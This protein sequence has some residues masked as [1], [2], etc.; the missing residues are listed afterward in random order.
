M[1]STA[2]PMIPATFFPNTVL[3]S[4]KALSCSLDLKGSHSAN[5]SNDGHCLPVT[6]QAR[7]CAGSRRASTVCSRLG[8]R[9]SFPCRRCSWLRACLRANAVRRQRQRCAV[10]A[11]RRQAHCPLAHAI[12]VLLVTPIL[13]LAFKVTPTYWAPSRSQ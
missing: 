5:P 3:Q 4:A 13:L 6:Q 10:D 9:L 1:T 12:G 7:H 8:P 2:S 11:A